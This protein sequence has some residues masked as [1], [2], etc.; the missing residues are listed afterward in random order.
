MVITLPSSQG[1]MSSVTSQRDITINTICAELG[2]RSRPEQGAC[3]E[4]RWSDLLVGGESQAGGTAGA[5]G[6]TEARSGQAA[7]SRSD[8]E[9]VTEQTQGWRSVCLSPWISSLEQTREG[10][11]GPG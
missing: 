7:C 6:E 1:V 3:W 10:E 4:S 2:R 8:S 5:V 11:F 9:W